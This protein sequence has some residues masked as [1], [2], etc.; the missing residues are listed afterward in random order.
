MVR[1]WLRR[2]RKLPAETLAAALVL[3]VSAYVIG[4][5]LVVARY[6]L[7]T[8]LPLHAANASALRH[9]FD[10]DWHFREQLIFQPL[11][12]PY[13]LFYVVAAG[14]MCVLPTMAAVKAAVFVMLALL[15]A[16]LATLFWGMRK[17]P[18]L[19]LG[20]LLFCWG[21]LAS[22]G[23]LNFMGALGLWA[24]VVG[25]ALRAVDRPPREASL[26]LASPLMLLFFSHPFR[27]P[28][29]LGALAV[30]AFFSC[31]VR[32]RYQS[33]VPA[34][35]VALVGGL[36][37]WFT[38][39]SALVVDLGGLGVHP[40][41][42]SF[43]SLGEH[44]YASLR[45]GAD[46]AAF[47]RAVAMVLLLAVTLG[48]QRWRSGRRSS[49]RERV[50][51]TTVLACVLAATLAYLV[52]PMQMGNW[53]FIY[54]RESTAAAFMAVG[55][56]PDLPR[57]PFGRLL[58]VAWLCLAV[59]PLGV[60]AV[61]SHR[62]FEAQTGDFARISRHIPPA[63]KLLY[64]VFDHAG[65]PA[66]QSPFIHLPGYVQAEKGG[67]TSFSFAWLGHSP[68]AFRDPRAPGAVVPPRPPLRWEWTP[69]RFDVERHGRFFDWF[70]VRARRSPHKLFAGDSSIEP[71]T[72][73]G[74]WWLYA[75]RAEA[76]ADVLPAGAAGTARDP[77][78][79]PPGTA[80]PHR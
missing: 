19:G 26:M 79:E 27:F 67:W 41:R 60:V 22:W 7:M 74:T 17:S 29:A 42:L 35:G 71:V 16:G 15:P 61:E 12:V 36:V 37:W 56:M 34:A 46:A 57:R 45:D 31:V 58:C 75:R 39:P 77:Q 50:A 55:L 18:L 20:G 6:P 73:D 64:L 76:P 69:Q 10:A 62:A 66:T 38:R 70:L 53:W 48:V 32:R 59:A 65:A 80:G 8:D 2:A 33:L 44:P 25:V 23:F 9:Y 30:V 4:A 13:M 68:L 52:L 3:A 5:P 1:R 24:M 14:F 43:S 49:K 51:H 63:P 78:A 11:A 28:M 47:R 40:E 72:H 21:S 54:P